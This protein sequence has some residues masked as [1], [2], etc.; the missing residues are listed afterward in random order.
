MIGFL[1]LSVGIGRPLL[2]AFSS[3][4]QEGVERAL[5]ILQVRPGGHPTLPMLNIDRAYQEE[6]EMCMRLLGARTMR[7]IVPEMVDAS[8]IGL[9]VVSVPS[10]RLYE[11]NCACLSVFVLPFPHLFSFYFCSLCSAFV[12]RYADAIERKRCRRGH[13][14][15]QAETGQGEVVKA[16][17]GLLFSHLHLCMYF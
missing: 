2:Y 12:S 14:G 7:E 16:S 1:V 11:K 4:G 6:F 5:E 17:G 8:N 3:Y 15:C 10:D 9:H 13:A